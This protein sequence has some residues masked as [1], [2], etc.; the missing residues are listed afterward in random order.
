MKVEKGQR[1]LITGASKGIGVHIA[2]ELANRGLNLIL[3]ARSQDKLQVL[4]EE[5][6]SL[7]V[8]CEIEALDVNDIEACTELIDRLNKQAPI[9]I[10]INNAGILL[11]SPYLGQSAEE[12]LRVINVNLSAPMMLSHAALKGMLQQGRGHIVNISSLAGLGGFKHGETYCA[13]KHGLVGFT[14]ALRFSLGGEKVSASVL[15]PGYISETG[16]Y[17]TRKE[18][19]DLEA[20]SMLGTSPPGAVVKAVI[21][22]IEKDLAEVIVNGRPVRPG[23]AIAALF[24]SFAEKIAQ[25]IGVNSLTEKIAKASKKD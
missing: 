19:H 20:P 5:F 6:E 1:A 23:L 16:M 17:A 3:V 10:L 22:A 24:P 25:L 13:S 21:R 2:R 14:R 9:D 8:Q 12:I 18:A 11:D 15:C 4:K 7:G